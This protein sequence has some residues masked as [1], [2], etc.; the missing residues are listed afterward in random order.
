MVEI[1]KEK[2]LVTPKDIKPSSKDFEVLGTLNWSNTL[3]QRGYTSLCE[4]NRKAD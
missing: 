4:G 3:T 1:K 2:V